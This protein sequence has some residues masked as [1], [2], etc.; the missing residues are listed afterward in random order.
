M[1]RSADCVHVHCLR[2][3]VKLMRQILPLAKAVCGGQHICASTELFYLLAGHGLHAEFC[4]AFQAFSFLGQIVRRHP[5]AWPRRSP[6]GSWLGSVRAWLADI[7]WQETGPWSWHH[8]DLGPQGFNISWTSRL[9]KPEIDRENHQ[10]R[11]SWR[12]A[13]TFVRKVSGF[14]ATRC[15]CCSR[16]F[17]F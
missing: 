5:R 4:A 13:Q 3:S 10:I 16:V 15:R 12:L 1:P 7:G 8:S 11:E 9:A 6:N 17:I 14:C 2:S